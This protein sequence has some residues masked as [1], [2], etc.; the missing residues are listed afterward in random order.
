M[1]YTSSKDSLRKSI[2]GIQLEIQ[3]T[4]YDEVKQEIILEK[5]SKI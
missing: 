1:L 5:I 3:G 2:V 4:D